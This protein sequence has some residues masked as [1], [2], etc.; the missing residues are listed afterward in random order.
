MNHNYVEF[1]TPDIQPAIDFYSNDLPNV[2]VVE[3]LHSWKSRWLQIPADK[4]PQT[5]RMLCCH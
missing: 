2:N 4:H 5:L 1:E 3:E